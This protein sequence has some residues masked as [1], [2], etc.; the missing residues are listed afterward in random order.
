MTS[1]VK[2]LLDTEMIRYEGTMTC[3]NHD[4]QLPTVTPAIVAA[5]VQ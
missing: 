4:A 1:H 2:S 3:D 5:R